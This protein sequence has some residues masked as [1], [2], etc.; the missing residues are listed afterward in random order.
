MLKMWPIAMDDELQ[1]KEKAE[2][3]KSYQENMMAYLK[4]KREAK[5]LRKL[6][7]EQEIGNPHT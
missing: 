6:K 5:A 3:K 4:Q 7:E 1:G 2:Q